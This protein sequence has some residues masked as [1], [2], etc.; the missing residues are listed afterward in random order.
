[1]YMSLYRL[2]LAFLSEIVLIGMGFRK[3]SRY[4]KTQHLTARASMSYY[5]CTFACTYELFREPLPGLSYFVGLFP[6]LN[7]GRHHQISFR[8]SMIPNLSIVNTGLL[9]VVSYFWEYTYFCLFYFLV[10][11]MSIMGYCAFQLKLITSLKLSAPWTSI[12]P[13]SLLA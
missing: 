12:D 9:I 3:S 5:V 13:L 1:M 4:G 8:E 7:G 6:P 10:S 2:A 11:D